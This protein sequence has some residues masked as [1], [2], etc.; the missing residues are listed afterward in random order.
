MNLTG[1]KS[2]LVGARRGVE[3]CAEAA[4]SDAASE[5]ADLR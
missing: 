1:S 2:F 5:A 3:A 4:S